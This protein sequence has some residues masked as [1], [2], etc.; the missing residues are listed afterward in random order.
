MPVHEREVM[1]REVWAKSASDSLGAGPKTKPGR[2]QS[3]SRGRSA[4][5]MANAVLGRL[6]LGIAV[7]DL[8]MRLLFWNEQAAGLFGIPPLMAAAHPLLADVLAGIP[9]LTQQQR[10]RIVD[11][12]ATHIEA[13]DRTEPESYLRLSLGRDQRFAFQIR[14]IGSH[15]W[16]LVID[17][18]KMASAISRNGTTRGEDAWL[19][20]LT[21]LS[22][23]RH[24]N[25]VL[26]QYTEDAASD[27]QHTL[28]LID[29]DRFSAVNETFGRPVGD[30]LL[31]IV[32][33]RLRGEI[34][35]DD[36]LVRLGGDEF[37]ILIGSSDRAEPLAKRVIDNLS[38]AFLVEGNIIRLGASVGISRY[39]E[40]AK[41]PGDL[42][43]GAD[44]ALYGAK[45]AGRATWRMF[46]PATAEQAQARRELETSLRKAISMGELS[47]A[48]QPQMDDGTQVL[49]GFEALLRWHHPTLGNVSPATFIPL[50]EEIGCAAALG[51]WVL[52]TACQEATQWPLPLALAV[53]VPAHQ[54]EDIDQL[55]AAVQTAL[56]LSGLT[57]G[58]LKLK[59]TA[60]TTLTKDA[61]ILEP[62]HAIGV[63]IAREDFD[64]DGPPQSFL[65][66]K[67]NP[68]QSYITDREQDAEAALARCS[69]GLDPDHRTKAIR[70]DLKTSDQVVQVSAPGCNENQGKPLGSPIHPRDIAT[71]LSR[72]IPA[73]NSI[74][75]SR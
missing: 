58:R 43:R 13:G 74:A 42:I 21:G 22:N 4:E 72:Y 64:T 55:A 49:N 73:T 46:D 53:K 35:D 50:A 10:D 60:S 37:A 66:D 8:D 39:S 15:R 45:R 47:L 51:E 14:G 33:Q 67:V 12:S 41:S 28:L 31:S 62:L 48:Y 1:L 3:A 70:S 24:F 5:R 69:V 16:M 25:Q 30:A 11:F 54:L 17:D 71:Y 20:P 34:R 68:D 59:I 63:Q 61:P 38:R 27:A 7:I 52:K 19:D 36:L 29:L 32:G 18:G 9:N 65:S 75:Q 44:L 6:P 26:D 57:P 40:A 23:R 2:R 56:T